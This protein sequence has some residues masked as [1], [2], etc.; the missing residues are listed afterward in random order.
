MKEPEIVV[1]RIKNRWHARLVNN[2]KVFDEM[3]CDCSADIGLICKERLR[4][5]NKRGN[6]SKFADKARH[7]ESTARM[8]EGKIWTYNQLMEERKSHEAQTERT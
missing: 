3:A 6:E 2:G 7:R 8:Q 4:W 1:T 5:F